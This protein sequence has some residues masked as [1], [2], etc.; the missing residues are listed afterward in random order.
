MSY[1][2]YQPSPMYAQYNGGINH[3]ANPSV[4]SNIYG[5]PQQQYSAYQQP[6]QQQYHN[7]QQQQPVQQHVQ[8]QQPQPVQHVQQPQQQSVPS[9]KANLSQ[10]HDLKS[11]NAQ[12]YIVAATPIPPS[13]LPLAELSEEEKYALE[14]M[15]QRVQ[16]EPEFK[17]FVTEQM[18]VEFLMAR[19]FEVERALVLLRSHMAWRRENGIL[20]RDNL[21]LD[22]VI[23]QE[24][25][26]AKLLTDTSSR[27]SEG[28]QIVYFRPCLMSAHKTQNTST[29]DFCRAVFFLLQRCITD[30]LTQ[31]QGFLFICD[32]RGTSMTNVDYRLIKAVINMLQNRFPGRLKR[33]LL[34]EPPRFFK[35]AFKMIKPL[36][37]EKYL[38]KMSIVT[39]PEILDHAPASGLLKEYGG[40]VDYDHVKFL[41]MIK[42]E[43]QDKKM[44]GAA[45]NPNMT[46]IGVPNA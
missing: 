21:R 20:N 36:I 5:Q 19:K 7:V 23:T 41:E 34:L 40:Q 43:E 14:E 11:A 13:S 33:V 15:K 17:E 30:P 31:R 42:S 12:S 18:M 46:V 10:Q 16:A 26:S 4:Q 37:A 39:M 32:L 27:D 2:S 3:Y 6:Q 35:M 28:A 9:S 45:V 38:Q 24:I 25:E 1:V 29:V 8:Q 44:H 22:P